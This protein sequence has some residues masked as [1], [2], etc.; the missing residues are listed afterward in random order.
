MH[1]VVVGLGVGGRW[2]EVVGVPLGVGGGFFRLVGVWL[3]RVGALARVGG[4][5]LEVVGVGFGL[6]GVGLGWCGGLRPGKRELPMQSSDLGGGNFW[7]EGETGL[8]D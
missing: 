6:V 4:D 5:F 3:G 1:L 2:L 8:T 7:N